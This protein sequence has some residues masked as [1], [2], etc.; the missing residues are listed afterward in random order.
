MTSSAIPSNIPISTQVSQL[1]WEI[2]NAKKKICRTE[3]EYRKESERTMRNYMGDE[4]SS[5]EMSFDWS[6]HSKAEIIAAAWYAKSLISNTSRKESRLFFP[7]DISNRSPRRR[8]KPE[9]SDE[10]SLDMRS[11]ITNDSVVSYCTDVEGL[12]V[13]TKFSK[14]EFY[15]DAMDLEPNDHRLIEPSDLIDDEDPIFLL[16]QLCLWKD[17]TQIRSW[18]SEKP[19]ETVR[20]GILAQNPSNL[21]TS[22]HVLCSCFSLNSMKSQS[23]PLSLLHR[24]LLIAPEVC[25]IPDYAGRLPI[26]H[27]V[28][29]GAEAGVMKILLQASPETS[30]IEDSCGFTPIALIQ[31]NEEGD[32]ALTKKSVKSTDRP[33]VKDKVQ[34]QHGKAKKNLHTKLKSKPQNDEENIPRDS[35]IA[36][37]QAEVRRKK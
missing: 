1:R 9:I 5:S 34:K 17:W 27:A 29:A 28:L 21:M 36:L 31:E 4:S 3:D 10:K 8:A 12:G 30:Q 23:P 26:H 11:R 7:A 13:R 6:A 15:F 35:N 32:I 20:R 16:Y 24:F 33:K 25:H 37:P 2:T 18:I 19:L 22:V 14:R